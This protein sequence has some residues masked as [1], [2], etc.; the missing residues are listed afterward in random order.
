MPNQGKYK[1]A[2]IQTMGRVSV[3]V[4]HENFIRILWRNIRQIEFI[5]LTKH[6]MAATSS[7]LIK[8]SK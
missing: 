5:H 6:Q 2:Q 7:R 4:L 3:K 8:P 1:L